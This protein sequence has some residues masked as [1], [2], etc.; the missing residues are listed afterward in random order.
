VDE[1][2]IISAE[3][4]VSQRAK[5]EPANTCFRNISMYYTLICMFSPHIL[6][7]YDVVTPLCYKNSQDVLHVLLISKVQ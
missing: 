6:V 5:V 4:S 7:G 1:W 3:L 2:S